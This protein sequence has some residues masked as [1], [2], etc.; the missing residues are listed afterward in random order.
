VEKVP[1]ISIVDDDA[2]M[3]NATR[4]LIKS[5]GLNAHTFASAEEFLESG[6]ARESSCVITDMQMPGLNGAELQRKLT[7]QGVNTPIIFV[8]AFPEDSLR[9][10]V[11]DAGAV[12]FLGKPFDE[13]RLI[14]C[15]ETALGTSPGCMLMDRSGADQVAPQSPSEDDLILRGRR[16]IRR[17]R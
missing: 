2:I 13:E 16:S 1:V 7:A 5:L 10:R 6:C 14:G 17:P 15:L 9:R 3:R 4:R 8:T 12:G 11:L